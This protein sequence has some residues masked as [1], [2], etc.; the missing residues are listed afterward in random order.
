MTSRQQDVLFHKQN[1]I[2]TITIT[3]GQNH[4][5]D[6]RNTDNGRSP[7]RYKAA[8]NHTAVRTVHHSP[9]QRFQN[10]P[11]HNANNKLVGLG[12]PEEWAKLISGSRKA[13]W[14]LSKTPQLKQI[15][16]SCL[17][18]GPKTS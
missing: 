1:Q 13:Y 17:L 2:A 3:H 8:R 6:R 4:A 7:V 15:P 16:W 10:N 14:R 5:A 12:I 9:A 11:L 18:A